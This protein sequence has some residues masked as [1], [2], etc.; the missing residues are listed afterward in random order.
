M[1]DNLNIK[2]PADATKI[3]INEPYEVNYWTAKFGV[4]VQQLKNAVKDVG[5]QVRDVKRKLER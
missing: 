2:R 3:N 1:P 4:S 5:P